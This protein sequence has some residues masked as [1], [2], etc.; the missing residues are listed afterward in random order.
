MTTRLLRLEVLLMT[1]TVTLNC[2]AAD[3]SLDVQMQLLGNFPVVTAKIQG[4]DIPLIFDLGDDLGLALKQGAI[5]R[6]KTLPSSETYRAYD[7]AG[8]VIQSAMF[9]VPQLQIGGAVFT[10]VIGRPD[11][12]DPSYDATE[13]G[14]QGYIGTA[15]FKTYKV[16]LDYRH[17]TMTLI[18]PGS[19]PD[20]L[21]KCKGTVVPFLPDWK[22]GRATKVDTDFGTLTAI[23]D[24]GAPVSILRKAQAHKVAEDA[25]FDAVSTRHLVLGGADFGPLKLTV[26]DYTEPA[27][28]DMYIGYNFF[29]KHVVCIDFPGKQFLIQR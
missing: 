11:L 29:A 5:D 3:R 14:Q 7:A 2:V 8:N 13:V 21:A 16:V 4:N 6:L 19:T 25:S 18:P 12:H 23:W 24:T 15:P 27:G 9:R 10:D 17:R 1:S 20:Q 28:T 22:G 26:A